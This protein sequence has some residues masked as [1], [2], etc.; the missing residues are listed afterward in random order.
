[1]ELCLEILLEILEQID[2]ILC[3]LSTYLSILNPT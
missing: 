1:M 3:V 2:K